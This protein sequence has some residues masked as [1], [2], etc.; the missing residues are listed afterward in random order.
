MQ[1]DY[2]SPAVLIK[3]AEVAAKLSIGENTLAKWRLTGKGPSYV[4]VGARVM[5]DAATVEAW[6]A[7]RVRLSTSDCGEAA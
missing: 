6:I 4:K 7:S 1:K 3:P 5:Y 2:R